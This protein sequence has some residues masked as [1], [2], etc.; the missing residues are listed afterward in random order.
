MDSILLVVGL[1]LIVMTIFSR[2]ISARYRLPLV[3]AVCG[4]LFALGFNL[5]SGSKTALGDRLQDRPGIQLKTPE[6][7]IPKNDPSREV[8]SV[9]SGT[10]DAGNRV[11]L[12]VKVG[13]TVADSLG[14][15][16]YSLS[17]DQLLKSQD[18]ELRA[19]ATNE[20]SDRSGFSEPKLI[21]LLPRQNQ[22]FET[23]L[24]YESTRTENMDYVVINGLDQV[25]SIVDQKSG[26]FK[27]TTLN[28]DVTFQGEE[29][30]GKMMFSQ[31]K[32]QDLDAAGTFE[33]ED[34]CV[35]KISLVVT[36]R[37][38]AHRTREAIL[39]WDYNYCSRGVL[40]GM[41]NVNTSEAR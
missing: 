23:G 22:E 32:N 3:V 38:I 39:Y 31:C 24:I 5:I 2:N 40:T 11:E 17:P 25:C 7:S 8:N 10:A 15:W 41:A 6:I 27:D 13:S 9:L 20:N 4:F 12:Y 33:D 21:N 30:H 14:N 16:S 26:V 34:N 18:F 28:Y 37:D 19:I 29:I 35:G 36:H 1:L